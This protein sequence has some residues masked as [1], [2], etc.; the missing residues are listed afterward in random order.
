MSALQQIPR[1]AGT[2][3]GTG[4]TTAAI[5]AYG[6]NTG[7][8]EILGINMPGLLAY[9][10]V[11]A[12]AST[13][14]EFT[15]NM[16]VPMITNDPFSSTAIYIA[17]PAITGAALVGLSYLLGAIVTPSDAIPAFL[18]GAMSQVV[19]AYAGNTIDGFINKYSSMGGSAVKSAT[20]LY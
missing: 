11:S 4:L 7:S 8:V 16:V 5:A 3:I 9:G 15:K 14:T 10:L 12:G 1:S 6:G 19:G 20:I 2:I 18:N 17:Q 13:V